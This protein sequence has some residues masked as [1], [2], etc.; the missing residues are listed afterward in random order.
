MAMDCSHRVGIIPCHFFLAFGASV[1]LQDAIT[2]KAQPG[3]S[4]GHK[5]TS[6]DEKSWQ[7]HRVDVYKI[8]M[9]DVPTVILEIGILPSPTANTREQISNIGIQ[10]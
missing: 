10:C 6:Q 3:I 2:E 5:I 7:S 9:M 8:P 1:W 4:Q